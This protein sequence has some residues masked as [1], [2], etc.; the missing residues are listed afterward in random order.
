[1]EIRTDRLTLLAATP[2]LAQAE[3]GDRAAFAAL[4]NATVPDAWPPEMLADALPWFAGQLTEDPT[5]EGWLGWYGL[6]RNADDSRTLVASGG[7][8]GKP[9][10]GAVEVGYSVLPDY[11]RHGYATEMIGALV[12]WAL[13]QTGVERVTADVAY[14]NEPSLRLLV[15]LGFALVGDGT[16]PGHHR[17]ARHHGAV[18]AARPFYVSAIPADATEVAVEKPPTAE[19]THK[20]YYRNGTLVGS[21][22]FNAEG[23]LE[24]ERAF[25]NGL[26]F[27]REYVWY[28][29]GAILSVAPY[30]GQGRPHGIAYQW[31][32]D[33]RLLGHYTMEHGTGTDLWWQTW[34]DGTTELA[35]IHQYRENE[36]HG[37]EWWLTGG[38]IPYIERRWQYGLMHGIDREW[39]ENDRL[40]RGFP[41]FWVHGKRVTRGEYARIA[42]TDD[43]LPPFRPEDNI[44]ERRFP[45]EVEERVKLHG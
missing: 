14:N 11:Q 3:T 42:A 43:T 9:S 28:P 21:R 2:A 6:L 10:E 37:Y 44:P 31:A 22:F 16:K 20:D 24:D 1:M 27:G 25:R 34:S 35:E 26:P 39:N 40:E 18:E 19:T 38:R 13:A 12:E 4:L 7:F 41:R 23:G 30:D 32:E 29:S 5:R 36:R 45:P 17:F 15:N 33:G 8:V